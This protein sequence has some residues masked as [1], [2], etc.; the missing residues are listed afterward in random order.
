MA[1]SIPLLIGGES[2]TNDVGLRD[3]MIQPP[4][5]W[6]KKLALNDDKRRNALR[7]GA[8]QNSHEK[9]FEGGCYERSKSVATPRHCR[10]RMCRAGRRRRG[11]V[12]EARADSVSQ[13]TPECSSY[14]TC[15]R[16]GSTRQQ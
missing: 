7:H 11:T 4:T 12:D 15:R 6:V 14:S 3:D 16:R 1:T 9:Q 10:G 2:R 5:I 13:R 8:C